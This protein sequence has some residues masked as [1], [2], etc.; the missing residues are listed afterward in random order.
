MQL[1]IQRT[2]VRQFK[3]LHI[4]FADSF[5]MFSYPRGSYFS[6]QQRIEFVAQCNQ[7]YVGRVSFV[8][9]ARVRDFDQLDLH[10]L[11]VKNLHGGGDLSFWN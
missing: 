8:A 7:P 9:R 1:E 10:E 6:N 5:E 3:S 4:T 2:E 11:H